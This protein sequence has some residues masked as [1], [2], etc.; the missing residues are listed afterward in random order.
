MRRRGIRAIGVLCLFGL[1]AC[2]VAD[3]S[4]SHELLETGLPI[5][6]AFQRDL[7][8]LVTVLQVVV[9]AG[10][11]T[12]PGKRRGLALLTART[13]LEIPSA[14]A[15]KELLEK[16]I[17][18]SSWVDGDQAVLS[19]TSLSEHFADSVKILAE[20]L[21]NPL[22]SGI[23]LQRIKE[24]MGNR[25]I[26]EQDSPMAVMRRSMDEHFLG[27]LGYSGGSMGCAE[28]RKSITKSDVVAHLDN[29]YGKEQMSIAVVSDLEAKRVAALLR[30]HFK[31]LKGKP[32]E[33]ANKPTNSAPCPCAGHQ[34][35]PS[36][37]KLEQP[38]LAWGMPLPPL[39]R[40]SF[41]RS[42]VFAR[43][44]AGGPGSLAW[45]LRDPQGLA[46]TVGCDLRHYKHGGVM[47]VYLRTDPRLLD[48]AEEQLEAILQELLQIGVS[49][50]QLTAAISQEVVDWYRSLQSKRERAWRLAAFDSNGL[51]ADLTAGYPELVKGLNKSDMDVF[52]RNCVNPDTRWRLTLGA[53]SDA[54][55][56][57]Q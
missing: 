23:R 5:R 42:R 17:Q 44:L 31:S 25:E 57:L 47:A 28:T 1:A 18:L 2:L 22:V 49:P 46:Y 40:E 14:L 21:K 15:V 37:R 29:H 55:E 4:E 7:G 30:K 56:N 41:V 12:V 8:S 34:N 35:A 32:V 19:M 9:P 50:A 26:A 38:L 20:M 36:I 16:G 45:K 11:R 39:N 54:R 48:K 10:I 53:A 24:W 51:G 3:G 27:P 6:V 52:I 43:L 13:A 33:T